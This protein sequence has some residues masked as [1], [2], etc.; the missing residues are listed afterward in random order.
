MPASVMTGISDQIT[1]S[2]WIKGLSADYPN[3]V[4]YV[5]F[6]S[7]DSADQ[8]KYWDVAGWEINSSQLYSGWNH[9][10]V[11][12]NVNTGKTYTYHNG[13]LVAEQ[14][15]LFQFIIGADSSASVL[16][17]DSDGSYVWADDLRI[18]S[19]ALNQNEI[20]YLIGGAAHQITQ[21]VN[22]VFTDADI[23]M[24]GK[25]D[26]KDLSIMC[27]DWLWEY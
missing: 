20:I 21:P 9:Y 26:I 24:D 15:N 10:A 4:D 14:T 25:I 12:K 18:Y 22:P 23:F 19:K 27:K 16:M 1:F 7:G 11:V 13:I 3:L 6:Q 17:R 8:K 2:I 5:S